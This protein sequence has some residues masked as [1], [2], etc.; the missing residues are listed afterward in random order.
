MGF[1]GVKLFLNNIWN[2][3]VNCLTIRY[4]NA[5]SI[6]LLAV[7]SLVIE[8]WSLDSLD[9]NFPPSNRY[10]LLSTIAVSGAAAVS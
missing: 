10:F 1:N 4:N 5:L 8:D 2:N 7:S 3:K 6:P 9:R